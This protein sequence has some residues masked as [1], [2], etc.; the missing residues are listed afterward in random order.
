M[1]RPSK[2][3]RTQVQR[4]V[5]IHEA[6]IDEGFI[7]FVKSK[8]G[9]LFP[10]ITPDRFGVRGGNAPKTFSR[11]IRE[12]LGITDPRIAPAHS[13]RHLFKTLCRNARITQETHDALTG[14]VVA[15]E[16]AEYG[17][18]VGIQKRAEAIALIPVPPFLCLKRDAQP[19]FGEAG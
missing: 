7:S 5:P 10:E 15:G 19:G 4:G 14:H 9:L 16:G 12:V 11:L 1:I 18:K 2:R 17:E 3:S 13:F 6:L 8:R